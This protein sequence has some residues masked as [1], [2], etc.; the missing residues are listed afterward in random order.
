[1]DPKIIQSKPPKPQPNVIRMQITRSEEGELVCPFMSQIV[2]MDVAAPSIMGGA[3]R[4]VM[5][6]LAVACAKGDC[7]VWDTQRAACGARG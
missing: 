4:V 7:A 6:A 1:M 5:Q 2:P 3:P